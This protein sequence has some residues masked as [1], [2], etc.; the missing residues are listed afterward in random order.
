V[1]TLKATH[2]IDLPAANGKFARFSIIESPVMAPALAAKF[3]NIKTYRGRGIDDPAATLRISVTPAGFSA[4]VLS[5]SGTQYIDRLFRDD[6]TRYACYA[7]RDYSG[8][9]LNQQR[10]R[11]DLKDGGQHAFRC[12]LQGNQKQTPQ[13]KAPR[14]A[15]SSG[16][17]LRTY[18]IAVAATGEYTA[19]HGGT[20]AGGQAAIVQAI[21]RITGVYEQELSVRLVLV[22]N[23]DQLVFTN[24]VTDPYENN[25]AEQMLEQNG[26]TLDE[27]IGSGNYDIG[28]VF[29]TGGGGLAGLGVVCSSGKAEGVTGMGDPVGDSF[30][31]DF[32]AHEIGHQF[33]ANH[34]F[35]GNQDS[36][37]GG[38]RNEPTAYEPGSGSTIMSYAGICGTDD[39]Q[40]HSDA[41]FS[42]ASYDEIRTLIE[43]IGCAT[44]TATGNSSPNINAGADYTIPAQT[45]FE[46]TAVGNDANAG[47]ILTYLWEERDLGSFNAPND[48]DNGSSPIFRVWTPSTNPT[49][50]FPRLT[51][52][53]NNTTAKGE[54]LPTSNRVM[55]FRATVRDNR[56]GGGGVNQDDTQITATT[57]A[58]PFL[59]TAPN[60]SGGSFSASTTVTWNVAKTTAS[61]VNTSHVDIL[62]STDGGIT[63]GTTLLSNTPNDGSELVTL[64][65]IATTTARIK[66]KAVNNIFFDI[67]NNNFTITPPAGPTLS[68]NDISLT[69]GDSGTKQA[70]FYV[71][72]N[73]QIRFSPGITSQQITVTVNGDT[74]AE[75][76]ETFHVDLSGAVNA[77][78]SDPRGTATITSDDISPPVISSAATASGTLT[79]P[80]FYQITASENPTNYGV[81]GILPTG[82]NFNGTT[83]E[84]SGLPTETG[85]FPLT[86]SATNSKGSNS[87][88]LSLTIST[89]PVTAAL[90]GTAMTWLQGG[91]TDWITIT[92]AKPTTNDGVDAA[93]SGIIPNDHRSWIETT[94]IGPDTLTFFWK[95]SSEENF[96]FLI[97]QIDGTE[98]FKISGEIPWEKHNILIPAG[99]HKLRWTYKKDN[100]Q[101]VGIDAGF[102][103][104]V[105]LASQSTQP[106]ILSSLDITAATNSPFFYQIIAT[107]Q[108]DTFDAT[109]LPPGLTVDTETGRITGTPTSTGT[110]S[111]NLSATNASGTGQA[112]MIFTV[113]TALT[114]DA[115]LDT[116]GLDIRWIGDGSIPWFSQAATT[117]DGT[118][119]VKSGPIGDDGVSVLQTTLTGPDI[120]I[121]QWRVAS[122]NTYDFLRLEL[123]GLEQLKITGD[124]AWAQKFIFIPP[125][126]HSVRWRYTK[127]DSN[128]SGSDSGYLDEVSLLSQTF[129]ISSLT[130]VGA[131]AKIH[132]PSMT[133]LTYTLQHSTDLKTWTNV[134]ENITGNGGQIEVTHVGGASST[135]H[136]Y[137]VTALPQN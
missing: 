89:D 59:V 49:R 66:V 111:L 5:P 126:Q 67:S 54:Q 103:D 18:R 91:D 74:D 119:A 135:R 110:F 13:A 120:L 3:P 72:K 64:P 109:G 116:E 46:L 82:I 68:I 101:N 108:P 9:K 123:D 117:H 71:A 76:N 44:N 98:Q 70:T 51:D 34:T 10:A 21:N 129:E 55:K 128:S 37:A 7:R 6:T 15:R 28:H 105:S 114:L 115:A 12:L 112:T 8:N 118:D 30:W 35:N 78:L 122:E 84:L 47:D 61:P 107:K 106:T 131:D 124:T 85:T 2:I 11:A 121:F 75:T 127:D 19:F 86:I 41:I 96:D 25:Q 100:K 26:I 39:I 43:S 80:F 22:A 69:E 17:T 81:V 137:R 95:V 65:A 29:S 93:R 79:A 45:P 32:V 90:D 134:Q 52:L 20:V 62:L 16:A 73:S 58:G 33:G 102:L 88:A 92:G 133:G 57:G 48:P 36:C 136:F 104:E 40:P 1:G 77:S 113:G 53:I 94:V 125:G 56:A 50:T 42:T 83:G 132:F 63:Y 27:K 4:Q 97:F 14:A 99:P 23:N 87:Q 24:S 31:I 38:N 130:L 60:A